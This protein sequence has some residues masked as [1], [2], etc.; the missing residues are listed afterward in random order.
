[1]E[2]NNLDDGLLCFV[3][4]GGERGGFYHKER[5]REREREIKRAGEVEGANT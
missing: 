1:M 3:A 4:K 2:D 5:E